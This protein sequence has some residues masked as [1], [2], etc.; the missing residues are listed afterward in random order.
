MDGTNLSP[1]TTHI[2]VGKLG[3]IRGAGSGAIWSTNNVNLVNKG[4]ISGAGVYGVG[5][6][7]DA[8][9]LVNSG[10][11]FGGIYGLYSQPD[12]AYHVNS[13][14]IKATSIGAYLATPSIST[15]YGLENSGKIVGSIGLL[16]NGLSTSVLDSSGVI[17][18]RNG[19]AV[20]GFDG[21][22]EVLNS[23]EIRGDISLRGGN[24]IYFG[25]GTGSV[26]GTVFGGLGNDTLSGS[27]SADRFDGGDGNDVLLGKGGDDELFGGIDD[28]TLSGGKG[29]DRLFG[30]DGIDDLNGGADNDRLNGGAGDDILDG[31]S[32]NDVLKGG[33]GQDVLIAGT[34]ND[35]LWGGADAD[36]FIF[37]EDN[38]GTDRIKDFEDGV[39][40]IDLSYY[41]ITNI[42]R[43]MNKA[44]S[45]VNGDV[46]IDM[47][48]VGAR[49]RSSSK[50][51]RATSMSRILFLISN[52]AMNASN[53]ARC[54]SL[55]QQKA[56]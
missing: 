10:K 21:I 27:K 30:G 55:K 25:S 38:V 19:V 56:P 12:Y 45:T 41:G 43:F 22:Q 2:V 9:A 42:T 53:W 8:A 6:G 32:G 51:L 26:S 28:D 3:E 44:V 13:G 49:V 11:I 14:L 5:F 34:G 36:M 17:V 37:N 40:Q 50:M 15:G 33:S 39:D 1:D 48:K 20:E 23:G 29:A 7:G 35:K 31:S 54:R 4:V 47:T 18:G 52:P 24:V 46:V 16:M